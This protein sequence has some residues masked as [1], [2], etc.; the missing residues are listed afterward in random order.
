MIKKD[1]DAV[2]FDCWDT[3]ISFECPEKKWNIL[4][5]YQHSI[6]KDEIDWE[7]V[8][9]FSEQFFDGYYR[10]RLN[11]EIDILAVLRLFVTYFGIV[12]DCPLEVCTHEILI[13]L[14]PKPID[15]ID[16][17]L[18]YLDENGI[19]YSVLSNTIYSSD[20]TMAL[21]DKL[22]PNHHF[23]FFLGS[24]DIGVKKPNPIFFQTGVKK[25]K[26]EIGKSIYI[27]DTFYQDVIGS[28]VSGFKSSVWL[29][30]KGKE[31]TFFERA[32]LTDKIKYI[33]VDSYH[34]LISALEE[35]NNK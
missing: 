34:S 12:L 16:Q 13:H 32:D 20:D 30:H 18:T 8:Y 25:A 17:F 6:N 7:K 33:E 22:V 10:S 3:L 23:G 1:L 4:S 26:Q 29:N 24:K 14:S 31:P 28:F 27:G 9:E 15:G 5:L 19:Y 11:Y 2:F 35:K 21:I